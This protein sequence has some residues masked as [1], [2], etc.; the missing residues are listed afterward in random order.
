GK[1]ADTSVTDS[2]DTTTLSLTATDSVAEGG[3]IVYTANLTNAAGTPVTVTLSNGAVITIAA[4][5]TSGSVTVKAPAD[6]VYK[7]A[8]KVEATIKDATGG[9][10][11]NLVKDP[12]AAVTD[13]TDTVDT[14][15]VSLTATSSVAEGGTVVYT[16]SVT[17]PVTGSP[18]VVSL[19]NGQTITIP[20]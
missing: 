3:S 5:A 2:A 1:S 8:G 13:V 15:T 7:D 4:G 20:V 6:D 14:S 11:E 18:V 10:F 19:S 16:A 9:N 12:A 17:A